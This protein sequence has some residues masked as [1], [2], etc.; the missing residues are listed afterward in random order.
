MSGQPKCERCDST[1]WVCENHHDKPWDGSPRDC[2][3]GGAGEPC[4]QCNVPA[5]PKEPPR[6]LAGSTVSWTAKDG[7]AN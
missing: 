3:C 7:W 4:P 6:F 5:N 2:G 1:G